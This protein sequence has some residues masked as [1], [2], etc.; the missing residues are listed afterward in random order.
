MELY[1]I[2]LLMLKVIIS[3]GRYTIHH[4]AV[5]CLLGAHVQHVRAV[6]ALL[7]RGPRRSRRPRL[8]GEAS[9]R[10]TLS[11]AERSQTQ[12]GWEMH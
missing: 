10:R 1:Q 12:G 9:G 4:D 2:F 8:H 3:R 6:P 11:A 7:R 5:R